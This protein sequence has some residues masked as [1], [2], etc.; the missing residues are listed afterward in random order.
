MFADLGFFAPFCISTA[1]KMG[2]EAV[3]SS[4]LVTRIRRAFLPVDSHAHSC[5]PVES[6]AAKE[7]NRESISERIGIA[8]PFLVSGSRRS[9]RSS[10][11]SPAG[12]PCRFP[13]SESRAAWCP[14]SRAAARRR[15][16]GIADGQ[17]PASSARALASRKSSPKITPSATSPR[18]AVGSAAVV[19]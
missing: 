7:W 11:A 15:R 9:S 16:E 2:F 3:R 12:T 5:L 6:Y 13:S 8:S 10:N 4:F 1:I 14:A 17:R 19:R 18:L